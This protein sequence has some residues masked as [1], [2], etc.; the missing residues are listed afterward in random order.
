[1]FRLNGKKINIT[2]QYY[3]APTD[4]WYK[5]LCDPQ[6]R[7][8]LGVEEVPDP[9]LPTPPEHYWISE[10]ADGSVTVIKKTDEQI[11]EIENHKTRA[12]IEQEERNTML[13][14]AVREFILAAMVDKAAS[15]GVDEPTLYTT[16]PGYKKLKDFDESIKTLRGKLK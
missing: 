2:L 5:N 7:A 13:P 6:D 1:M 10:E 12:H 15:L 16:N 4:K 9:I 11:N 8:E 14:R 3:H